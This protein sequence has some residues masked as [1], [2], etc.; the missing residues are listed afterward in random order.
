MAHK[1]KL[2]GSR[3]ERQIAIDLREKFPFVKTSREASQLVDNCKVDLCGLP[4]AIQAKSG[5]NE[6]R[7]RYDRLYNEFKKLIA[8]NLPPN[9]AIHK[10][11][12]IL[13][14]KLNRIVPGKLK[15]PEMFQVTMDYEFFLEL[16]KNYQTDNPEI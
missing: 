12:Y 15:Q 1:N 8:E 5:Y 2:K 10:V 4:L 3:L 6:Q 9:H 11:P 14:N 16:I 7:L 13:I